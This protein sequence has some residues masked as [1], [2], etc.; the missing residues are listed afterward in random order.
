MRNVEMANY[1]SEDGCTGVLIAFWD[2]KSRGT[3]HMIK[4]AE[5]KGLEIK[6]VNYRKE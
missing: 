3:A 5:L 6:I 2:G 4:V 1:A